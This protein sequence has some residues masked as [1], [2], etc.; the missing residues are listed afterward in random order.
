MHI[1]LPTHSIGK[2]W[3]VQTFPYDYAPT[4]ERVYRDIVLELSTIEETEIDVPSYFTQ[5]TRGHETSVIHGKV[6]DIR[7][8]DIDGFHYIAGQRPYEEVMGVAASTTVYT[9]K[10][11]AHVRSWGRCCMRWI[12]DPGARSIT[13]MTATLWDNGVLAL[14]KEIT[15]FQEPFSVSDHP[16]T[17][18]GSVSVSEPHEWDS[19]VDAEEFLPKCEALDVELAPSIGAYLMEYTVDWKIPEIPYMR[20]RFRFN[21]PDWVRGQGPMP[22]SLHIAM[23]DAFLKAME[24]FPTMAD[25][26]LSNIADVAGMVKDICTG[27]IANLFFHDIPSL[28][29]WWRYSYSTTKSDVQQAIAYKSRQIITWLK[30]KSFDGNAEVRDLVSDTVGQVHCRFS[31]VQ[32]TGDLMA[33]LRHGLR[34]AGI[35]PTAYR[36]WDLIPFSFVIDWFGDVGNRLAAQE[37]IDSMSEYRFSDMIW[38]VK[39]TFSDSHATTQHYTRWLAGPPCME[40]YQWHDVSHPKTVTWLK[41]AGDAISMIVSSR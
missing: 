28:W 29:M 13:H 27:N 26:N 2:A 16:P 9:S 1:K 22:N 33:T 4:S 30:P 34:V 23:Q 3:S 10:Q 24:Q 21:E 6:A 7:Y 19:K 38:S 39:Y 36:A 37:L 15:V 32:R 25:N 8:D 17:L 40:N 31:V 12:F 18:W 35:L 11:L 41:R 14:S 20:A 5:L